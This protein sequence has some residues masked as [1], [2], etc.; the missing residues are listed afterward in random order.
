MKDHQMT[1]KTSEAQL[2]AFKKYDQKRRATRVPTVV[3][4][5]DT[6]AKFLTLVDIYGSKKATVEAAIIELYKK[7]I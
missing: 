6:Y 1:Q 4:T 5:E 2:K 7:H 3:L